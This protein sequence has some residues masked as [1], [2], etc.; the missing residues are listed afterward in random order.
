MQVD[1]LPIIM[2]VNPAAPAGPLPTI[3]NLTQYYAGQP[4]THNAD[5]YRVINPYYLVMGGLIVSL[6]LG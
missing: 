3:M 4:L 1:P 5:F 6:L 2:Q